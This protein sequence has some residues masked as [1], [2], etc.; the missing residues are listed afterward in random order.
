MAHDKQKDGER[1]VRVFQDGKMEAS[2]WRRR[3]S[4][5]NVTFHVSLVRKYLAQDGTFQKCSTYSPTDL[6]KIVKLAGDAERWVLRQD[7]GVA[8]DRAHSAE[9]RARNRRDEAEEKAQAAE[10][11]SPER[12]RPDGKVSIDGLL[13]KLLERLE[14]RKRGGPG[15]GH[16]L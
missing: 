1:P 16:S 6:K 5:G 10:R 7:R 11:E 13:D 4:E 2:V 8:R 14:E 3:D 12:P 9:L 15:G